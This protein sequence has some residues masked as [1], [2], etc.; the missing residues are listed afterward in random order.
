MFHVSLLGKR[1]KATRVSG[2]EEHMGGGAPLALGGVD[3]MVSLRA[4]TA[5]NVFF[6]CFLVRRV[7][8]GRD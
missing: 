1:K 3:L 2:K 7:I 4:T 6:F 5:Y 8:F